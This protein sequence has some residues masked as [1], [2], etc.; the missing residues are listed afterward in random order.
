MFV[1]YESPIQCFPE[2]FTRI[3]EPAFMESW[4]YPTV[5]MN[6]Y[7]IKNWRIYYHGQKSGTIGMLPVENWTGESPNWIFPSDEG[8][9]IA[10][11]ATMALTPTVS[12]G[13]YLV[14]KR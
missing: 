11:F 14:K 9:D 12:L 8:E 5:W 4:R 10:T 6:L 7:W 3:L 2:P 13:L 1:I